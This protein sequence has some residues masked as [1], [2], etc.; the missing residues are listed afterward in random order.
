MDVEMQMMLTLTADDDAPSAAL[1]F[2]SNPS[3]VADQD[4]LAWSH[5]LNR[6]DNTAAGHRQDHLLEIRVPLLLRCSL[7]APGAWMSSLRVV[8]SQANSTSYRRYAQEMCEH[9]RA[10]TQSLQQ[11]EQPT[12][13]RLQ[14]DYP[15]LP[16]HLEPSVSLSA[17]S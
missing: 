2:D 10:M 13:I 3:M 6:V 11:P 1:V 17:T 8:A 9:S 14:P 4:P 16:H 12:A 7:L 5:L 15:R